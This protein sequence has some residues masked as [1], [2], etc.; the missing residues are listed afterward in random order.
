MPTIQHSD[1]STPDMYSNQTDRGY[2]N[3]LKLLPEEVLT[4]VRQIQLKNGLKQSKGEMKDLD[5]T[6]EMETGT[7]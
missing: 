3:R 1:K 5:F 7:G 2:A 4:N 6:V